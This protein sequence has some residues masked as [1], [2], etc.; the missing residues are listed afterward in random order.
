MPAQRTFG[1]RPDQRLRR[2]RQFDEVFQARLRFDARVFI[3]NYRSNDC[4]FDRLGLTV[5]RKFGGAVQRNRIKRIVREV[6]RTNPNRDEPTL[7]LVFRPKADFLRTDYAEVQR[8]W[9]EALAAIKERFN[10]T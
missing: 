5:S 2:S 3:I 7:D 1:F 8:Q 9:R 6:F 4:G 10:K